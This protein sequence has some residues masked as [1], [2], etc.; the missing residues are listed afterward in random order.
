MNKIL[1]QNLRVTVAL[2]FGLTLPCQAQFLDGVQEI[3]VS[4][5]VSN[6]KQANIC[7]GD[8]SRV[9]RCDYQQPP[10]SQMT[11]PFWGQIVYTQRIAPNAESRAT[12]YVTNENRDCTL[13][14]QN[15]TFMRNT[16]I[17][18]NGN[19]LSWDVS[20][21]LLGDGTNCFENDDLLF[22]VTDI[23][24]SVENGLGSNTKVRVSLSNAPAEK[25]SANSYQL[26]TTVIKLP[27]NKQS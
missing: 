11:V 14:L 18:G 10:L 1:L 25:P 2:G 13:H 19:V 23:T 22:I 3:I 26:Q 9:T 8:V 12:F 16:R 5:P 27:N 20:Q 21:A 15:E 7:Y 24:V 4:A 17:M 6:S